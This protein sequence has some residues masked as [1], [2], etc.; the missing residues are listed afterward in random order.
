MGEIG[1]YVLAPCIPNIHKDQHALGWFY[2]VKCEFFAPKVKEITSLGPRISN[3]MISF[4]PTN[5][6]LYISI[7]T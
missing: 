4:S 7:R 2:T 6:M 1:P 3:V 5:L